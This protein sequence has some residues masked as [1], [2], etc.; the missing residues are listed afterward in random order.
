ME[1]I[2]NALRI[3]MTILALLLAGAHYGRAGDAILKYLCLALPLLLL[4]RK[5]WSARRQKLPGSEWPSFWVVL[6]SSL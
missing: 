1:V 5:K 2:M 6:R 4:I 3:V